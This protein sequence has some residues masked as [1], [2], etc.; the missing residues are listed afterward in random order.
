VPIVPTTRQPRVHALDDRRH[1]A[2][3]SVEPTVGD[4][5]TDE[6]REPIWIM[7]VYSHAVG[8]SESDLEVSG[9]GSRMPDEARAPFQITAAS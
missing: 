9:P 6:L 2:Q 1:I 4:N 5:G 7:L 3:G 8:A